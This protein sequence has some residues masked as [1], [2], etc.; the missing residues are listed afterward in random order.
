MASRNSS[1]RRKEI[2][3]I[4][5]RRY[6]RKPVATAT[7]AFI[8]LFSGIIIFSVLPL[9]FFFDPGSFTSKIR[10][11]DFPLGMF[12]PPPEQ[13]PNINPED[14][15]DEFWEWLMDNLNQTDIPE[16][17][18]DNITIPDD[19]NLP[20]DLNIPSDFNFPEDFDWGSIPP[21]LLPFLAA[22]WYIGY[23]PFG[24]TVNISVAHDTPPRFWRLF[25]YDEFDGMDWTQTN[26]TREPLN[27][28]APYNGADIYQVNI[29]VTV[30]GNGINVLPLPVLWDSAMILNSPTFN[31]TPTTNLTWNLLTN[32]YNDAILNLSNTGPD[33]IDYEITYNVSYNPNVNLTY[34][35]Q[36]INSTPPAQG[37]SLPGKFLQVPNIPEIDPYIQDFLSTMNP[38]STINDTLN[39]TYAALEYFKTRFRYVPMFSTSSANITRFLI[40]GYGDSK[41]FA[42]AFTIFL[43]HLNIS[44]RYVF[45]TIGFGTTTPPWLPLTNQYYWTEVWVP[46]N[47]N[48]GNWVQVD[49][50][51][52]PYTSYINVGV[53]Y[54]PINT[55][56]A[57]SRMI[58]DHFDLILTS[59]VTYSTIL[60]RG[61]DDFELRAKLLKNY[62]PVNRTILQP[63]IKLNFSD[64]TDNVFLGQIQVDNN[65]ESVLA[66][67]FNSSSTVGPHKFNVTWFAVSNSTST[68]VTC[69]GTTNIFIN[70]ING[71]PTSLFNN[72]SVI[73]GPVT[74]F[75]VLGNLT[76]P[77]NGNPVQDQLIEIYVNETNSLIGSGYTDNN[78][79]FLINCTVPTDTHYGVK[80]FYANFNSTFIANYPEPYPDIQVGEI[81]GSGS[82][83]SEYKIVII[84]TTNLT[85]SY[86]TPIFLNDNLTV[87]GTLLFD[88]S[89]AFPSQTVSVYETNSSGEFLVGTD[90]TAGD[91]SYSVTYFL[92]IDHDST[93]SIKANTSFGNPFIIDSE[94]DPEA[95]A[96]I[97]V[98]FTIFE[99]TPIT[100]IRDVTNV[101]ISGQVLEKD[102]AKNI[103]NEQIEIRLN[104]SAI[105]VYTTTNETGH[106]N[107]TFKISVSQTIG[108]YT[109]N[110]TTTNASYYIWQDD[111]NWDNFT[112]DP[113][114]VNIT[115]NEVT[116]LEVTRGE[117]SIT[118]TGWV[119]HKENTINIA[120]EQMMIRLGN[121][122]INIFATTNANGNFSTTFTLP[123]TVGGNPISPGSY[124]I[125]AST[126]SANYQTFK[127]DTSKTI[128]VNVSSSISG[129]SFN[130]NSFRIGEFITI[131]GRITD[132]IGNEISGYKANLSVWF[133][134]TELLIN[135][136]PITGTSGNFIINCTIPAAQSGEHN[137]TIMF[138]GSGLYLPINATQKISVFTTPIV[139]LATLTPVVVSGGFMI[140]SGKVFDDITKVS[141]M[142]RVVELRLF[143]IPITQLTTNSKGEFFYVLPAFDGIFVFQAYFEGNALDSSNGINVLGYTPPE[144]YD[145]VWIIVIIIAVVIVLF[146]VGKLYYKRWQVEKFIESIQIKNFKSKLKSLIDGKKYREAIV[147]LY[148]VFF[149]KILEKLKRPPPPGY[150]FREL[151]TAL[152]KKIRLDPDLVY[153]FTSN[154]EEARYSDHIITPALYSDTFKLFE[155]L[156]RKSFEILELIEL[157]EEPEISEPNLPPM[158]S[159]IQV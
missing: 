66:T 1:N 146:F 119:L 128:T 131:N 154:Y 73:R 64:M 95:E 39:T 58:T 5:A 105:N 12:I 93:F 109:I 9:S 34:I 60:N 47:T 38:F 144:N 65:N 121:V 59:N 108:V 51:P 14:L 32:E 28:V 99:V 23:G 17:L 91:G 113:I 80:H 27:Y 153:P 137:I 31:I 138:N 148:Q 114:W 18:F 85:K 82:N 140:I 10:L 75:Q 156:I 43:R 45:G 155:K 115:I 112:V 83:S 116:P 139:Q 6:A 16:D 135:N 98:N 106:F 78:G 57:D 136:T 111:T 48:G 149:S 97:R 62:I 11:G 4:S 84:A 37:P 15:P 19:W 158:E 90:S 72:I 110:A 132:N 142:G 94:A 2:E 92:P 61:V 141:I 152:V 50:S 70:T 77:S 41:D 96:Y 81:P 40:N 157:E 67:K 44:A 87:S 46:N 124:I 88:N 56:I 30:Q 134:Q 36:N 21:D 79:E 103:S 25:V 55:R 52:V 69:N 123:N 145:W 13:N 127:D 150:T 151:M 125:N 104:N 76:D 147:F 24:P 102:L 133:N 54:V 49:P 22:M 100:A 42:T 86:P 53:G 74:T 129:L 35:R 8:L 126:T 68:V 89:S 7:F 117:T 20:D 3:D 122:P 143:D 33:S 26:N 107:A 71:T 118:L 101:F 29:N 130:Y 120:N 159:N 63:L